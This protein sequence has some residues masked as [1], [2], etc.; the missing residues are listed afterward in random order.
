MT[1]L[2]IGLIGAGVIATGGYAAASGLDSQPA[3]TTSLPAATSADDATTNRITT[4]ATPAATTAE[5]ISG[6]CD[7][8][9]HRNDPRCAGASAPAPAPAP[10]ATVDDDGPGDISGPCDEAEHRNDARCNGVAATSDDNS[11]PGRDDEAESEDH[12][13]S[14][15]GKSRDDESE[16]RGDRSGSDRGDD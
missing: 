16:D 9:E 6:P 8:A 10:A 3:R 11:G 5:D 4:A 12:D 1:K 2:L 14:G 13:N 15:H 7:E